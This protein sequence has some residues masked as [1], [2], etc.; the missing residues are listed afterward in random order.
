MIRMRT[1]A[2]AALLLT[3]FAGDGSWA[4]PVTTNFP[5]PNP[6]ANRLPPQFPPAQLRTNCKDLNTL[7]LTGGKILKAEVVP[8]GTFMTPTTPSIPLPGLPT[9]C[10]V[11]GV[12]TPVTRAGDSLIGFEVWIPYDGSYRNRYLQ[13]GNGGFSG[14]IVYGGLAEGIRRGYATA[15]TDD[16][17][18]MH[19]SAEFVLGH[20]QK[21]IDYGY[22]ALKETTDKAKFIIATL[23]GANPERSYFHGCSNGGREALMEAQRYPNDFD[24]IVVG[25]PANYFTH[26]FAGFVWNSQRIY[27]PASVIPNIPDSLLHVLSEAVQ[28]Q[29]AGHD[30]GLVGDKFL[31]NPPACHVNFAPITCTPASPAGTCFT[32]SQI[33]IIKAIYDGPVRDD[34]SHAQIYPG[35]E[36]G[37]ES[38]ACNWGMWITGKPVGSATCGPEG[39][40]HV[41]LQALFGWSF[42][43]F[44]VNHTAAYDIH[45]LNFSSDIDNADAALAATLNSIEPDLHAFRDHGGK[46]IQYHGW[47]DTAV[48]PRNS[49]NYWASVEAKMK[50]LDPTF[51]HTDLDGFYRLFMAPGMSHCAGGP[52]ATAFGNLFN[53]SAPDADHDVL[54]AMEHWVEDSVAPERI[55]A[56]HYAEGLYD[57]PFERPLCVYPKLPHYNGSGDRRAAANWSCVAPARVPI[58]RYLPERLLPVGRP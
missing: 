18:Q 9:F 56:K 5:V 28:A 27:P 51:S 33:D 12:A 19:G 45:A 58:M 53:G 20:P 50:T 22:R 55:I 40:P 26:Q 41:G 48:A 2:A 31:T 10:R 3:A 39:L 15:S 4:K 57:P 38:H 6:N 24:G 47:D 36:P 17:S 52:G 11:I 43:G 1:L 13:V 21:V 32:P 8:A 42:F 25:A 35:F 30:G 34:A 16:G 14:D 37:A 7:K 46:L 54:R 29:C 49:I 23:M 44:F